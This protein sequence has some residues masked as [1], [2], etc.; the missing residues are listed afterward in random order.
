MSETQ[1]KLNF[2]DLC[3]TSQIGKL[4]NI[5]EPIS[6]GLLHRMY[7]IETN[8]G[9][10]AIKLLNPQIMLRP[11]ALQNYINSE[12]IANFVSNKLP[13]LTSEKINGRFI[14]QVDSQFY[15][16]FKWIEGKSLKQDEIDE[17]S[18]RKN[19][20]NTCRYTQN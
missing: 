4:V 16:V 18:L 10:Y 20:G 15:I 14:Q 9:K 6:G 12:R 2:K 17:K 13:A 5:P 19:R 1:Y 3:Q 8:Q 7:Y 11:K